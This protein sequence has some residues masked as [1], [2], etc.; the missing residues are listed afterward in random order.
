VIARRI[1][2][3]LVGL[4]PV[5]AQE[6]PMHVLTSLLP[7]GAEVIETAD[8]SATVAKPRVVVLWMLNPEHHMDKRSD[9]TNEGGECSDILR[10]EFGAYWKG[11]TRLSLVDSAQLKVINSIEIRNGSPCS[12][13]GCGLGEDTFAVPFCVFSSFHPTD[14]TS[15]KSGKRN[16]WLRDFTGEGVAVQFPMLWFEAY[17]LVSTGMFRVRIED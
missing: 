13:K 11:P 2:V 3:A 1:L 14:G 16:L 17:G 9:N 7:A 10:G 4:W 5:F 12:D 6:I 8:L 15:V